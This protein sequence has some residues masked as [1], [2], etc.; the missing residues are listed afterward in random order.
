MTATGASGRPGY[1]V[2]P[3]AGRASLQACPDSLAATTERHGYPRLQVAM[4]DDRR[5][6]PDPLRAVVPPLLAD[7]TTVVTL[8]GRGPAAARNTGWRAAEPAEWVVFLDDVRVSGNWARDLAAAL[9]TAA[10]GTGGVQGVLLVPWPSSARPHRLP[11]RQPRAGRCG[12][13]HRGHGV[14]ARGPG[15]RR[16]VR[17]AVPV[18]TGKTATRAPDRGPRLDPAARQPPDDPSRSSAPPLGE[19]PDASRQ[20]GRRRDAPAPRDRLAARRGG[21]RRPPGR[22][23][24]HLRGRRGSTPAV[25]DPGVA[26]GR[27]A[28]LPRGSAPA[29]RGAHPAPLP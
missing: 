27:A 9:S 14:P 11:A 8:E 23:F 4:A 20:R 26:A 22:A 13:D 21:R 1:V 7:R 2:I 10:P 25:A 12:V 5:D 15:R 19:Y 28:H 3:T 16:R 29:E 17:R 18:P 24:G 6:T